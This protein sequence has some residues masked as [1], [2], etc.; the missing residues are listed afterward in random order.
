MVEDEEEEEE[1]EEEE[2]SG[3]RTDVGVCSMARGRNCT[4]YGPLFL[5]PP[6]LFIR[7]YLCRLIQ[8]LTVDWSFGSR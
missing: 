1:E 7:C 4:N 3:K 6:L 5:W 2:D 8:F